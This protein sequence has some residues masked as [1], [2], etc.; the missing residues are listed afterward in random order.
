M[1]KTPP[2]QGRGVGQERKSDI[3][4]NL[5]E[6]SSNNKR[7]FAYLNK[8]RGL[9]AELINNLIDD[10][11]IYQDKRNNCVFPC[12]DK[13][14]QAKGAI[15]RGTL[16]DKT[17]K[18]RAKNSDVDYGWLLTPKEKAKKVIITE[19]PIDAMSLVS[20]YSNTSIRSNYILA[21]GGLFIKALEKFLESCPDVDTIILAVDNDAHGS[22][23]VNK[24]KSSLGLNYQIIEF[25]PRYTKDWNEELLANKL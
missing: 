5:P 12:F 15:L 25:R 8:T 14:G 22:D 2:R 18:G 13:T 10:D 1:K 3:M 6:K 4:F 16:T 7:V 19:A 21:L 23:F 17:F 24:V 11:L 20:L 9:P